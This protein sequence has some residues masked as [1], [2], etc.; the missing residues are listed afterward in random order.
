MTPLERFN[1]KSSRSKE[2]VRRTPRVHRSPESRSCWAPDQVGPQ[3]DLGAIDAGLGYHP[4]QLQLVPV[5]GA[6]QRHAGVKQRSGTCG[7]GTRLIIRIGERYRL[8]RAF[9]VRQSRPSQKGEV[10]RRAPAEAPV[11]LS[12]APFPPKAARTSLAKTAKLLVVL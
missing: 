7:L 8:R 11:L 2:F 10:Q 5:L 9:P 12:A 3:A 4:I 6:D 1:L